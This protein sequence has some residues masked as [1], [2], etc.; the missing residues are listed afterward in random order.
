MSKPLVIRK[1]S[2][3][4][5]VNFLFLLPFILAYRAL[6]VRYSFSETLWFTAGT[7]LILIIII[8][9][10]RLAY[11]KVDNDKMILNLHYYQSA[12]VHYLNRITLV[13]PL[14][15]H[16]CRIH[17]RDFKPVRLSMNPH[18]LKKLLK[19]LSEKEIKIKK[20]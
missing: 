20:I 17:S 14:N 18:D 8:I 10:N 13:E 3:A 9:S 12:E 6:M 11:V 16:S 1:H 15:R 5:L 19:L 2:A 4:R 7:I